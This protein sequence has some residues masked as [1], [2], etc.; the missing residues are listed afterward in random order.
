MSL[1]AVEPRHLVTLLLL[2]LLQPVWPSRFIPMK[3]PLSEEILD[4]WELP[5]PPKHRLTVPDLLAAQAAAGRR[6]GLL[7]DLSNHDCLYARDVPNSVQVWFFG[8]GVQ[9]NDGPCLHA[10][11]REGAAAAWQCAWQLQR[12][13]VYSPA[14]FCSA[15]SMHLRQFAALLLLCAVGVCNDSAG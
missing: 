8:A 3:T 4:S 12:A 11:S 7:L 1:V 6:V 2:L 10:C 5:Q 14:G 15:T 9:L 13:Q